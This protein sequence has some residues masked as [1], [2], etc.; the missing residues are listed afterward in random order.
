M[1]KIEN[2]Q[3]F[4]M[5]ELLQVMA[6]IGILTSIAIPSY[7]SWQKHTH[8]V[9]TTVD[10]NALSL[11]ASNVIN[12]PGNVKSISTVEEAGYL[13]SSEGVVLSIK[14][15]RKGICVTGY[16]PKGKKYTSPD[17]ALMAFDGR[18]GVDCP[19]SLIP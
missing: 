18:T 5:L 2:E 8:D 15:D 19:A 9:E 10:V 17:T 7:L 11:H 3:G 14:A 4:T 13:Y 1:K 16:D 6:I 12:G